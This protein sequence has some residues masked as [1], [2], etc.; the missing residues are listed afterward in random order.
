MMKRF[1][2][3]LLALMLCCGTAFAEGVVGPAELNADEENLLALL[4]MHFGVHIFDFVAPEGAKTARL[5][6]WTRENGAWSAGTEVV[7]SVEGEGRQGRIA[8]VCGD[9]LSAGLLLSLW[10]PEG[11]TAIQD[12]N[13]PDFDVWSLNSGMETLWESADAPLNAEIPLALQVFSAAEEMAEIYLS[14]Y[15]DPAAIDGD[16]VFAVT[17]NFLD[18][19]EEEYWDAGEEDWPDWSGWN[20][21]DPEE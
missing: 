4:G 3:L 6:L 9:S 18:V 13:E 7:L 12:G 20:D 17:V 14:L 21:A 10:T 11:N 5:T 15:A 19:T 1:L 2:T 8:M 16:R